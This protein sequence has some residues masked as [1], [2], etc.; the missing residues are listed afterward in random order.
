VKLLAFDFELDK[1]VELEEDENF[2]DEQARRHAT[3]G[4]DPFYISVA[5]LL[6][7]DHNGRMSQPWYGITPLG[8]TASH[9]SVDDLNKF[10]LQIVSHAKMGFPIVTWNGTGFDWRILADLT[11]QHD[12][13]KQLA[14]GSYDPCYQHLIEYGYPIKLQAVAEGFDLAGKTMEGAQAPVLWQ[15]GNFQEVLNYVEQDVVVLADVVEQSFKKNG[16]M[17]VTKTGSV[18]FNPYKY[19]KLLSV[20]RLLGMPEANHP[21]DEH[22]ISRKGFDEWLT[23]K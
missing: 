21:E 10:L 5:G 1:P 12:L 15:L 7:Q 6:I 11:G 9:M 16:L 23:Q 3:P 22:Y 18:S 20:R 4:I 2:W 13:V 17:R 14:L 19:G 8:D